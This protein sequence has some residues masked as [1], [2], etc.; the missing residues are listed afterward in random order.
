MATFTPAVRTAK[1]YNSV[2]IRITHKRKS[3]YVKTNVLVHK[4]GIRKGKIVSPVVIAYA[5]R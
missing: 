3:D 5:M 4:S 1:E 2:H